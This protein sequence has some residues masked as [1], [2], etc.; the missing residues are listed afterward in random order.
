MNINVCL[1][2]DALMN[3]SKESKLLCEFEIKAKIE[4]IAPVGAKEDEKNL[5]KF[6]S[7]IIKDDEITL[8]GYSNPRFYNINIGNQPFFDVVIYDWDY[9]ATASIINPEEELNKLIEK[10]YCFIYIYSFLKDVETT[11]NIDKIKNKL[12]YRVDY[13][14][15]GEENSSDLLIKKINDIKTSN[16]SAKFANELRNNALKSVEKILVSLSHL[17]IEQF[18]N[19]MGTKNNE[20]K[21]RDIL[22]FISEKFKNNMIEMEFSLPPKEE[23]LNNQSNESDTGAE[24]GES[25]E[26]PSVKELWNYRMYTEI[27]SNIVRK[28]DIYEKKGGNGEYILITTPDC[29]LV[30]YHENKTFGILNYCVLISQA[31]IEKKVKQLVE[32]NSSP[33]N[34]CIKGDKIHSLIKQIKDKESDAYLLPYVTIKDSEDGHHNDTSLFLFPKMYSYSEIQCKQKKVDK[35]NASYLKRG[36]ISEYY[37][38]ITSLNEPFLSELIKEIYDKL[39]G[40]GVPDY[41][42]NFKEEIGKLL[43]ACFSQ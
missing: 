3:I 13:L 23:A 30:R 4:E 37:T 28:G 16:F 35:Q 18:H 43:S 25:I 9:G 42:E 19:I 20:E 2:D 40:N 1:I 24:S 14:K 38:Y 17:D 22:E 12:L 7:S 29:Q 10:S 15:K 34:I 36:D 41:T 11:K 6:I 26:A 5:K 31:S 27:N 39:Q 21:K 8:F 33:K 32:S